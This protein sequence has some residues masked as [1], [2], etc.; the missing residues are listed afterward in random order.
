MMLIL[1]VGIIVLQ[2][3]MPLVITKLMGV[4]PLIGMAAATF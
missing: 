4:N 1:L 2:N 3:A